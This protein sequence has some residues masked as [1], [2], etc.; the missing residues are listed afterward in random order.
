LDQELANLEEEASS[1]S[2]WDDQAKAQQTLSTLADVKDKI[3]LLNEYKTQ[4][5]YNSVNIIGTVK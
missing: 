1:S 3:K 5:R 2:F 4:V